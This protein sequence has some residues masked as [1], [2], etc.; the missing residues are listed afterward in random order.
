[1][2]TYTNSSLVTHTKLIKNGHYTPR[3]R[4]IEGITI[5]HNAGVA[6]VP[7]LLNYAYNTNRQMSFN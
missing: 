2:A 1:M 6:S 3:D 5:H 7:N 4:A